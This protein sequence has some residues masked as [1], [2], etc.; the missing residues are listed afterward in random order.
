MKEV[1]VKKS[2]V[3][4]IIFFGMVTAL[5]TV[6]KGIQVGQNISG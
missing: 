4:F 6:G 2:V 1:N 5:K 3:C